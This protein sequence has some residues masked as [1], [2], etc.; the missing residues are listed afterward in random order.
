MLLASE[1]E[2]SNPV[3]RLEVGQPNFPTPV[4]I[5]ESTIKALQQNQTTYV[6]NAGY[7]ELRSA[8]CNWYNK[9]GFPTDISQ[10]IVT[11][12]SMLSMYSL[13]VALLQ[14]GDECLVPLPGFGNYQQMISLV[15]AKSVPYLCRRSDGYLPR[16][17]EME[18]L[19]SPATKCI[20][21]CNP[22][23]PTGSTF[24]ESLLRDIGNLC[25][26]RGVFI[27]SDGL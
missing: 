12:G 3:L 8:I 18:Q 15:K 22:G 5:I 13:V 19:I 9:K 11:A 24:N 26:R 17:T 2:K 6:P 27:I 14:E 23:N 20:V 1:L 25:K 21:I 4:H 10:I 16:V 7:T